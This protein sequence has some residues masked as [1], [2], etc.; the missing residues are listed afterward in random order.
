MKAK[1]FIIALILSANMLG[2]YSQDDLFS[3]LSSNPNIT[4]VTI[5]KALLEMTPT[6]FDNS[7]GG[8]EIN[9]LV[10][11]LDQIDICTAESGDACRQMKMLVENYIVKNKAYEELMRIKDK[12]SNV[13]FYAEKENRN[14]KSLIML[15]GETEQCTLIRLKGNFTAKDIQEIKKGAKP[16]PQYG[17]DIVTG[18]ELEKTGETNLLKAIALK[19]PGVQYTQNNLRIRGISTLNSNTS[20]L[21]YVDGM[22]TSNIY[23]SSLSVVEVDYVEVIKDT[24]T[25]MFGM[26]G[27]NGAVM[28]YRKK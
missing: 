3:K 11:K 19:V 1:V 2:V 20:P 17:G 22:V 9:K 16:A 7:V 23:V 10:H 5:N 14:F 12:T 8:V 18:S 13:I 4:I 21:Y 6:L 26:K 25:S 27:S 28:V 24:S 15:L